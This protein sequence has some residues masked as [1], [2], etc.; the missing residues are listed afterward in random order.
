MGKKSEFFSKQKH[1]NHFDGSPRAKDYTNPKRPDG[2]INTRPQ[3][4]MRVANISND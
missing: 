3:Q 2:S 4:R 1:D